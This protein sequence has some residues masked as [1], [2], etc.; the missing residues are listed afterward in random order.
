MFRGL[1]CRTEGLGFNNTLLLEGR[2]APP[3]FRLAGN[4]QN[5]RLGMCFCHEQMS[6]HTGLSAVLGEYTGVG[7]PAHGHHPHLGFNSWFFSV[8]NDIGNST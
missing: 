8:L 7:S 2:I 5:K 6:I 1:G 4:L 3:C